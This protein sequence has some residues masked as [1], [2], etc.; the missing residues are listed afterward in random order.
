[1]K[2]GIL[3]CDSVVLE[4]QEAFGNY[5]QMFIDLFK[6]IDPEI[7]TQTYNVEIGEYPKTPEDCDVY[8]T[9]GS[10]A[11]VYEDL[12]WLK[13]FKAY[14]RLLFKKKIKFIGICFGHQLIADT[15]GGKTEKSD[16]GWGV[17]VSVNQIISHKPWMN[18]PLEKL[19]II[20]S[21]Q[22][23]V[24]KLPRNAELLASSDFCPNYMY[25]IDNLVLSLQG[26]PEFSKNY[27]ETLMRYRKLKIKK[28]TFN[29]GLN[30][31][32]LETHEKIF[33][34]WMLNFYKQAV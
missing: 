11:S 1:M 5:P 34:Q 7:E 27:S 12:P 25:Q 19:Q 33:A 15:F 26:H 2:I 21:H 13:P 16:K 20:V 22:D 17:G 24:I 31:L 23:Q 32:T 28:D 18:P 29:A 6:R 14:L 8:I 3:Q 4:Y 30:S 9:T 10:K